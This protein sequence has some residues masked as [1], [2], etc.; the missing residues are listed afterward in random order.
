VKVAL[1]FVNCGIEELKALLDGGT[2]TVY[3][4]ARPFT[5]DA[6][7]VEAVSWRFHLR[8]ARLW[9]GV[10]RAGTPSFRRQPS[11]GEQCWHAGV[12]A[13]LQGRRD[14]GCRFLG[15]PGDREIK[16]SEVSFSHGAPVT[17][18]QFKVLPDAAGPRS[19]NTTKARPRSGFALPK[20]P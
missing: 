11:R 7:S 13:G 17:L 20:N 8:V 4:V 18:T 10:R 14:R 5:P 12:C 9:P 3:S 19:L 16:F 6:P 15:R 2:L 1:E